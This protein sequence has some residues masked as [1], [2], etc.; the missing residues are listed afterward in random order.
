[1]RTQVFD[2]LC[3]DFPAPW[4]NATHR[5][6]NLGHS[7]RFTLLR[8]MSVVPP[9]AARIE[10][11]AGPAPTALGFIR[12]FRN[13]ASGPTQISTIQL[14]V[15]VPQRGGSRSSRTRGGMR[16]TRMA[17][18]DERRL[19]RTAKSCGPDAPTLASSF[20]EVSA[21]RWW[22]TSPVTKESAEETVKTIARGM[23]GDPGVTV[24]TNAC[25][26][27]TLHTRLRAHRAPGIP[28]A[29]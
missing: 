2:A 10:A 12:N 27:Y 1:M 14:A 26:F 28:C 3:R 8:A 20:A 19:R 17:L 21:G 18:K 24:V 4:G 15:L 29:L 25:A 7:R 22:Q 16:W 23:P 11:R 13:I 6:L 9:I 5:C